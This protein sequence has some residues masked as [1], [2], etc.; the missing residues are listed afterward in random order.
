MGG[1]ETMEEPEPVE[2]RVTGLVQDL[3]KVFLMVEITVQKQ[4]VPV[5]HC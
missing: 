1:E 3:E 4:N 2:P 5:L